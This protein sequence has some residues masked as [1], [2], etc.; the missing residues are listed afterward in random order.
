[1]TN[2]NISLNLDI[3]FICP[4]KCNFIIECLNLSIY[5]YIYIIYFVYFVNDSYIVLLMSY[6][7]QLYII[8][9]LNY[10]VNIN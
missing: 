6:T 5:I 7:L 1:M 2:S 4:N 8:S 9:C 3:Y 10:I